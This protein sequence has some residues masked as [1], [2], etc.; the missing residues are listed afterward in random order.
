MKVYPEIFPDGSFYGENNEEYC[1]Q[2]EDQ[3]KEYLQQKH[4]G[5][6]N[7]IYCGKALTPEEKH[8]YGD[9]C[10]QCEIRNWQELKEERESAERS[11]PPFFYVA[12][13]YTWQFILYGCLTAFAGIML[14]T[15]L[16][17]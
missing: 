12:S 8:Y 14:Y 16:N 3:A 10:E 7:C 17:P 4:E 15:L 6:N 5:E 1:K 13:E 2:L 11:K 9:T